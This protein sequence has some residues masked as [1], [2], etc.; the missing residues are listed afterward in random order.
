MRIFGKLWDAVDV[1]RKA[2]RRLRCLCFNPGSLGAW[3]VQVRHLNLID[4]VEFVPCCLNVRSSEHLELYFSLNLW[5]VG[6]EKLK[7]RLLSLHFV[8]KVCFQCVTSEA[9]VPH[10][11]CSLRVLQARFM[12]QGFYASGPQRTI[13]ELRT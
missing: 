5:F 12:G 2:G 3:K 10:S 6:A 13:L 9:T 4:V 7:L 8:F 11:R 1:S